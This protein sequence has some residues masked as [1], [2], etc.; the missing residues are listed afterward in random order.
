MTGS[1]DD[2]CCKKIPAC[3]ESLIPAKLAVEQLFPDK[4][5]GD[6]GDGGS[7]KRSSD[8][9]E[10]LRGVDDRCTSRGGQKHRAQGEKKAT[11]D[12]NRSLPR[13]AIHNPARWCLQQNGDHAAE[14]QRPPDSSRLPA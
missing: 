8:T 10:P 13:S 9:D 11:C 1:C 2:C 7:E 14:S 6:S 4:P 3:I 12:Q 5:H